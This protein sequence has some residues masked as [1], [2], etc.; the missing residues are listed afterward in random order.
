MKRKQIGSNVRYW[1]TEL[2]DVRCAKVFLI[3]KLDKLNETDAWSAA[4]WNS[5]FLSQYNDSGAA[6]KKTENERSKSRY[7]RPYPGPQQKQKAPGIYKFKLL[8]VLIKY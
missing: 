2:E 3:S 8:L 4:T 5:F 6:E 7:S 1:V